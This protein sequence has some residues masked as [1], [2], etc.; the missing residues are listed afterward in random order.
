M[1]AF[2]TALPKNTGK[3]AKEKRSA[4]QLQLKRK[5]GPASNRRE[6]KKRIRSMAI[7]ETPDGHEE[8]TEEA[9]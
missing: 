3:E 9:R 4:R 2:L 1:K 7:T 6:R 5:K 8:V